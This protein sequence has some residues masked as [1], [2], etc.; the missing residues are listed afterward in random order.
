[1]KTETLTNPPTDGS[2]FPSRN[3]LKI[4]VTKTAAR[5]TETSEGFTRS[6]G[7]SGKLS[8]ATAISMGDGQLPGHMVA[9]PH[10][11]ECETAIRILSG[12][13]RA[14]FGDDLREFV[15]L[16]QGDFLLIPPNLMHCAANFSHEAM[17]YVLARATP[18]EN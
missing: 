17:T 6:W 3:E 16:E 12:R 14:F 11:H 5:F 18:S 1:M 15:D 10:A 7:V 8:G 4:V 13:C 9:I 2:V